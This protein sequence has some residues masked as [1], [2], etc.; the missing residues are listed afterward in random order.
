VK[1][2]ENQTSAMSQ[3]AGDRIDAT[4]LGLVARNRLSAFAGL[5]SRWNPTI[6]L[7]SN[8]DIPHLWTR[9]IDDALQLIQYMP[10]A[11]THAIDLGSGG[12]FPGLVL[13]LATEI[14]VDLIES[15]S[16][17]AAFLQEV[18][19]ITNA[20]AT[21]HASRIEDIALESRVLVTARALAPL[22]KLLEL[23]Q[24]FLAEGGVCLFP[25]G[26]R[27]DSEIAEACKDWIMDLQQ[28]PSRTSPAGR[29][30]RITGLRRRASETL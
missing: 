14:H 1:H 6:K 17:K 5:L 20:H 4:S 13:A 23:C 11:A 30:L 10:P 19:T 22:P 28:M 12:G 2:R 18:V 16:R 27:A 9:H 21:I 26:E 24:P 25:K 3:A 8:Q 7:V 29:I 15:D